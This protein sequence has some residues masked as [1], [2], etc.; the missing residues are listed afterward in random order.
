[1]HR[2]APE[3]V[4]EI[5][6]CFAGYERALVTG[7]LDALA[8]YFDDADDTVRFGIADRQRGSAALAAFR[9]HQGALPPGR[10]LSETTIATFGAD[11]AI[12]AT[13]FTYP[14]RP[15]LGRQSQTWVR[16][17]GR[18][19]IVHAHVSEIPTTPNEST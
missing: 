2:N 3:V 1:V 4:A 19:K 15:V 6:T 5:A 16:R 18:W 9:A 12:V 13:L 14:G 11:V 7:D 10:T 8:A 17:G